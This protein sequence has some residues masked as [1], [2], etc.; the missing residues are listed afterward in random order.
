MK[1]TYWRAQVRYGHVGT[2]RGLCIDR[3]LSMNRNSNIKDVENL[4]KTMPGVKKGNKPYKIIQQIS[5]EEYLRGKT[6]E[7][8]NLFLIHLKNYHKAS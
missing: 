4:I 8:N 6:E 7:K 5:Q 2:G 3:H 1:K